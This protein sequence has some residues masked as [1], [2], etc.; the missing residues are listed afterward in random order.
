[1]PEFTIS[2]NNSIPNKTPTSFDDKASALFRTM[3]PENASKQ[4]TAEPKSPLDRMIEEEKSGIGGGVV[5]RNEDIKED[6]TKGPVMTPDNKRNA[7]M[8]S[9]VGDLDKTLERRAHLVS[10]RDVKTQEDHV[11][12]SIEIDSVSWDPATE[13]YF[14]LNEAGERA[15]QG[16]YYRLKTKEEED[17]GLTEEEIKAKEAGVSKPAEGD[18]APTDKQAELSED[19]KRANLVK[20]IIKNAHIGETINFTDEEREKMRESEQI[21]L[22]KVIDVTMA[23]APIID[24]KDISFNEAIQAYNYKNA[25]AFPVPFPGSGFT[26][27]MMSMT[28]GELSDIMVDPQNNTAETERQRLSVIY[29]KMTNLS[30]GDFDSFEDFARNFAYTD[31]PIAVFGLLVS[32]FPTVQTTQF[33][34][35]AE[36]KDNKPCNTYFDH[37][38]LTKSLW[39]L[40]D[41]AIPFLKMIDKLQ[42]N[43]PLKRAEL[44]KHSGV[45]DTRIIKMPVTG[46]EVEYGIASAFQYINWFV[47]ISTEEGYAARFPD[48]PSK[49]YVGN[50]PLLTIVRAVRLYDSKTNRRVRYSDFDNVWEALKLLTP[51]EFNILLSIATE[52][53][54]AYTPSFAWTNVTCPKCGTVTPI[55]ETDIVSVTFQLA[56]RQLQRSSDVFNLLPSWMRS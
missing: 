16:V 39:R 40:D 23:E 8:N 41:A 51:D 20:V 47:P 42:T 24:E 10:I 36:G 19:E 33:R 43:D 50:I 13:S 4:V 11:Q 52:I 17:A 5:V 14:M 3:T 54:S 56:S 53:T 7:S 34:C 55:A 35:N 48:D 26:A 18:N 46:I 1:M 31:I 29:D 28:M 45:M 2:D 27:E 9:K 38:Y 15:T 21:H 25:A 37:Q 30:V 44:R 22:E 6:V 49:R 32:T 12:A